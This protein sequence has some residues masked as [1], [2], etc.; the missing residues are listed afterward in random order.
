MNFGSTV[1]WSAIGIGRTVVDRD[2][3]TSAFACQNSPRPRETIHYNS[4]LP[5]LKANRRYIGESARHS[6]PPVSNQKFGFSWPEF[7]SRET[8]SRVERCVVPVP[9]RGRTKNRGRCPERSVVLRCTALYCA[10]QR[11]RS[12]R[13]AALSKVEMSK[14]RGAVSRAERCV[15]RSRNAEG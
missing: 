4:R 14:C 2:S 10:A 5:R 9:H 13:S 11:C 7:R 1:A 8:P 6:T 15:E 12:E 3:E